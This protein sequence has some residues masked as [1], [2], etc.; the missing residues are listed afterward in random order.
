MMQLNIDKI[1]EI[2][3]KKGYKKELIEKC[4]F[5]KKFKRIYSNKNN[6]LDVELIKILYLNYFV[7]IYK[8]AML[9]GKIDGC[10]RTF[11]IKNNI[12][13]RGHFTGK[14]SA[15]NFFEEIDSKEKA[16]FLG[17][18]L[19]DGCV[20]ISKNSTYLR[21]ELTENDSYILEEFNKIGNFNEKISVSDYDK[22]HKPKKYININSKKICDDLVNLNIVPNKSNL[23]IEISPRI[24]NNPFFSHFI[25]GF[26]DGDGIAFKDGRI[27]FCGQYNIMKTIHSFFIKKM[28]FSNTKI[29][30][31]KS[32][33]IYYIFWSSKKDVYKFYNY[34]YKD[35]NNLFLKR[36]KSKIENKIRLIAKEFA[37]DN[38]V[39]LYT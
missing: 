2:L 1:T 6:N 23:D 28:N 14:N 29:S 34:I 39:N 22:F 4:L 33:K 21:I 25:R 36:K 32:N 19:A 9:I 16:Y 3:L 11:M 12:P 27:G 24:L 38:L 7:P 15:N 18:I 37:D 35:S 17:L 5:A 13:M 10:L 8:I 20:R 30:Y 31:N 26:F